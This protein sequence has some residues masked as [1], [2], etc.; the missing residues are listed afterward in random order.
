MIGSENE[1]KGVK[2]AAWHTVTCGESILVLYVLS[3]YAILLSN[4]I[5][6]G[7]IGFHIF[8]QAD[9]FGIIGVHMT[10]DTPTLPKHV[11]VS[12]ETNESTT[13]SRT[14]FAAAGEMAA[15][16]QHDAFELYGG[17]LAKLHGLQSM[18]HERYAGTIPWVGTRL[19]L[20]WRPVHLIFLPPPRPL[21]PKHKVQDACALLFCM[22]IV[23]AFVQDV[24]LVCVVHV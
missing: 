14:M 11:A 17:L 3:N 2:R 15:H 21:I 12:L 9:V 1:W 19:I 5:T 13:K 7:N 4:H 20:P 16:V 22:C 18:R 8:S 23:V 6:I 10:E 24:V